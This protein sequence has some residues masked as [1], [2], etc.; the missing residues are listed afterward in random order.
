MG[1]GYPDRGNGTI[2][3][4]NG[5]PIG[6]SVAT[7]AAA[8]STQAD[9]TALTGAINKV[10]AADG[11]KGAILPACTDDSRLTTRVVVWNSAAAVLKVYPNT[12]GTVNGGSANAATSLAANTVAEFILF[13]ADT[14]IANEAAQA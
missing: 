9:A 3:P 14:W 11:T 7:I 5:S 10:T 12:G 4:V 8:G 13:D 6:G 1:T 2:D